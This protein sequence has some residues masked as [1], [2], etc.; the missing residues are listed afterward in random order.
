M[1]YLPRFA[2]YL[3]AAIAIAVFPFVAPND[4][5]LHLAQDIAILAI[6]SL[7]LNL[8][9]GYSGQIS[10]GQSAFFALGAYGLPFVVGVAAAVLG[11]RL[12]RTLDHHQG[13]RLGHL[14]AVFAVM[15]GSLAAVVSACMAFGVYGW[16]HVPDYYAS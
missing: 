1:S 5:Y 4:F 16:P 9:L 2:L 12:V 15:V 11:S 8:L 14:F 10:L 7:G 3:G 13:H 6:A